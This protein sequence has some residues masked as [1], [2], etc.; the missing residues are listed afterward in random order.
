VVAV[1][2]KEDEQGVAIFLTREE[3][4]QHCQPG[5]GSATCIWLVVGAE[6]FE[7]TYFRRP[8][9]LVEN[10]ARNKTVAKRNGCKEVR[11]MKHEV[12]YIETQTLEDYMKEVQK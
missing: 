2:I 6:G 9:A 7:C 3:V 12:K 4:M 10:W 8:T 1:K 5:M 11:S